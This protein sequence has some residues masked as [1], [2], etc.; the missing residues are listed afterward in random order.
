M[1]HKTCKTCLWWWDLY[2]TG[3]RKCYHRKSPLFHQLTKGGC[4]KFEEQLNKRMNL[5][6]GVAFDKAK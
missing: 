4:T 6:I 5:N 3:E 2:D 1:K